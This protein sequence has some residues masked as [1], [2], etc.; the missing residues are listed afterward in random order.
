MPPAE[1]TRAE[2]AE[3][4]RLLRVDSYDVSLDLTRGGE[5][6]GSTSVVRFGCAEPGASSYADLIAETVREITLNGV[7]LDPAAARCGSAIRPPKQAAAG[8]R[9]TPFNVI[10]RTVS[11]IRSA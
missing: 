1:I 9:A 11:A 7:A 8:S 4:A 5:V 10:S 3:R 6:F 2:T